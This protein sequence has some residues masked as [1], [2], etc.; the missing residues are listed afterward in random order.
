MTSAV[1]LYEAWAATTNEKARARLFAPTIEHLEERQAHIHGSEGRLV[2]EIE[3]VR[4][5]LKVDVEEVRGDLR[6][7]ELGLKKDIEQVRAELKTD[8]QSARLDTIKW[9]SGMLG[10]QTLVV[11]AAIIGA[12]AVVL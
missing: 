8:V 7:V 11:V 10:I 6:R 2:L 9:V 4:A 1:A 3:K 5:E 12:L